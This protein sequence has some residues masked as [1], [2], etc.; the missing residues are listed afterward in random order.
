M[1]FFS[2]AETVSEKSLSVQFS[3][4]GPVSHV[5]IDRS[6]GHALVFFQQVCCSLFLTVNVARK[7]CKVEVFFLLKT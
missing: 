1:F 6:R 7:S 5:A 3:Q 4:F 2:F